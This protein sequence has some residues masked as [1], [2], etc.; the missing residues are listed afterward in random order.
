M[1]HTNL[2][3]GTVITAGRRTVLMQALDVLATPVKQEFTLKISNPFLLTSFYYG[4]MK[5]VYLY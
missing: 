5:C 3:I 4:M 2:S 1:K